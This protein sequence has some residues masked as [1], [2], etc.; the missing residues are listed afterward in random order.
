MDAFV[1]EGNAGT[2]ELDPY[3]DDAVIIATPTGTERHPAR[4][5]QTRAEA[6]QESYLNTQ[7]HFVECLRSGKPAQNEIADNMETLAALFAAYESAATGQVIAL[8]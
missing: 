8:S 2:I 5:T 7:R 3:Q 4:P 6:Y 1:V